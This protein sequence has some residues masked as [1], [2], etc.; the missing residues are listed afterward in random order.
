M[1]RPVAV[2]RAVF[3]LAALAAVVTA[4]PHAR[5]QE[6]PPPSRI[7]LE[8]APGEVRFLVEALDAVLT[9]GSAEDVSLESFDG[10]TAT[11][12]YLHGSL[13]GTRESVGYGRDAAG[14]R[15]L[16]LS[17]ARSDSLEHMAMAYDV[18]L[19]LAPD[20][21]LVRTV[22]RAARAERL[23]EY[24]AP[25]ARDV[26][27][28]IGVQPACAPP[29]CDP[30]G[31]TVHERERREVPAFWFESWR[32]AFGLAAMRGEAWIGRPVAALPGRRGTP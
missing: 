22:D 7:A 29:R 32:P 19:D 3:V 11:G 28:D 6:V 10:E 14:R 18:D 20:F 30:A 2:A 5:A 9:S 1:R 17:V 4:A 12:V 16:W 27:L 15:Y 26:S 13:R 31:W 25:A 24:R 8:L 21:L 23:T